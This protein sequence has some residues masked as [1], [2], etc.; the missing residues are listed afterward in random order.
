MV[1][2]WIRPGRG[3]CILNTPRPWLS[4]LDPGFRLSPDRLRDESQDLIGGQREDSEH[5]M[6]HHLGIASH[7]YRSPAES[8]FQAY[9]HPF[10]ASAFPIA[11]AL[12]VV[13]IQKL[14]RFA[15]ACN[16]AFS[17][18]SR[19]GWGRFLLSSWSR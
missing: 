18:A 14:C 17:D 9:I 4:G 12:G 1:G 8:V 3:N 15:S 5:R 6:A 2:I 19:R 16:S 11:Q 7:T 13:V 10:H